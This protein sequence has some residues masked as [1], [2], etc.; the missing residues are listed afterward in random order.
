MM[1]ACC[2]HLSAM[3]NI[4]SLV[5]LRS[6]GRLTKILPRAVILLLLSPPP[7]S[8]D[9]KGDGIVRAPV[10]CRFL[11]ALQMSLYSGG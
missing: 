10:Y 2:M 8:L 9:S 1:M 4:N 7:A 5:I 11:M 6:H 3:P